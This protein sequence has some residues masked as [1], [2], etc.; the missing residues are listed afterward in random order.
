MITYTAAQ[1]RAFNLDFDFPPP[2]PVRKTVFTLRLWLPA[3]Y[4]RRAVT[5]GLGPPGSYKG[6]HQPSRRS[7]GPGESKPKLIP[8]LIGRQK[9]TA[10][11]ASRAHESRVLVDVPQRTGIVQRTHN[12]HNLPTLYVLNAAAVTKPHAVKHLSAYLIGYYCKKT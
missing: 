2:R 7:A 10:R 1:L 11:P 12:C 3:R 8:V 6:N 5:T 9:T 4:R